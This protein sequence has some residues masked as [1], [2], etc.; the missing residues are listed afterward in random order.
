MRITGVKSVI[1]NP[2]RNNREKLKARTSS[3]AA[4]S[5]IVKL[6]TIEKN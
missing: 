1:A 3:S 5:G 6:E 4:D 2:T